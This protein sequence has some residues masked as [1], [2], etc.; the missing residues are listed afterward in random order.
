MWRD[1]TG[2]GNT[3]K[4]EFVVIEMS[5]NNWCDIYFL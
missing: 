1:V 3:N 4:T 5:W 2:D